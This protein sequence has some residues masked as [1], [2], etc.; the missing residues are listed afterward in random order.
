MHP[1]AKLIS[2]RV[3]HVLPG[4]GEHNLCALAMQRPGDFAANASAS[5]GD[6]RRFSVE[7][8]H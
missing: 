1:L 7:I 3:K 4:A 2:Q 5:A 8:K 6:Q